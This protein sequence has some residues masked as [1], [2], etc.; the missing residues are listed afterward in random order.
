MCDN[1]KCPNFK[2]LPMQL[3]YKS[4]TGRGHVS[5][6]TVSRIAKFNRFPSFTKQKLNPITVFRKLGE[7]SASQYQSPEAQLC[8]HSNAQLRIAGRPDAGTTP[9]YGQREAAKAS[10]R[11]GSGYWVGGHIIQASSNANY[12]NNKKHRPPPAGADTGTRAGGARSDRL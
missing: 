5:I 12:N 2:A 11:S 8:G 9:H 7:A 10:E 4:F 3:L 6:A 1:G